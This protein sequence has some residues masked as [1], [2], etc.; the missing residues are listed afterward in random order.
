M[1]T[2]SRDAAAPATAHSLLSLDEAALVH[3]LCMLHVEDLLHLSRCCRR[4]H[5]LV[6]HAAPAW[7]RLLA[8]HFPSRA[9]APQASAA[10]PGEAALG[11]FRDTW[12]AVAK[13]ERL[14]RRVQRMRL[15]SD[16]AQLQRELADMQA[17]LKR[18]HTSQRQLAQQLQRL[19]HAHAAS[20][21]VDSMQWQLSAVKL[22]HNAVVQAA[23]VPRN[24]HVAALQ[25]Q[26]RV[27]QLEAK[28]LQAGIDNRRQRLAATRRRLAA[29]EG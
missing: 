17:R 19:Q 29:L 28:T 3:V 1:A 26:Q 7:A 20:R 6:R 15:Q 2:T 24:A 4:L 13:A 18:E 25:Q 23:R 16:A 5:T 22:Y 12:I 27:A 14:T 9:R 21:A 10:A 8:A 11:L